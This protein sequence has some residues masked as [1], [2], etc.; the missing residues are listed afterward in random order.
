MNRSSRGLRLE[1][2]TG[3]IIFTEEARGDLGYALLKLVGGDAP[4][5][6]AADTDVA[7]VDETYII[8]RAT[9]LAFGSAGHVKE[10]YLQQSDRWALRAERAR[11]ALHR[12]RG[13][14]KVA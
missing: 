5:L 14:R 1:P 11:K 4:A 10:V 3:D 7:E 9:E 13:A 8:A 12:L 2:D 6:L